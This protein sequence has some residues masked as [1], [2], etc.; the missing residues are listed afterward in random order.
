MTKLLA[1]ADRVLAPPFKDVFDLVAMYLAW[2]KIPQTAWQEA[3]RQYGNV[4][5]KA[6]LKSLEDMLARPA[7][8][9]EQAADMK[10]KPHWAQRIVTEGAQQ[11]HCT[12]TA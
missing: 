11:L 9:M 1:N 5:R 2:G 6:L 8:Y 12:I 3:E 4:P 7:L 10:M